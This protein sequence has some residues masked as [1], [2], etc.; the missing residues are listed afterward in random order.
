MP[1]FTRQNM[2]FYKPDPKAICVMALNCSD[3]KLALARSDAS[4]EIWNLNHTPFMEKSFTSNL[5]NYSV[6]GLTWC[7]RRLFSTGHHGWLVELDL[8]T[9]TMKDKWSITGEAGTC[10]D[11]RNSQIVVGTEQG[12]LNIFQVTGTDTQFEKFLDKQEGRIVCV[13]LNPTGE[14]VVAGSLNAIRIWSV[15]TGHALHKMVLSRAEANKNTIVWC[16]EVLSDFTIVSGDSR[17]VVTFWDGKLG[18]QLESYHSQN[19]DIRA[20]CINENEDS[21]YCSGINQLI[22]NYEK[23]KVGSSIKWVK[24]VV[25][26]ID[27]H[28]VRA[29]AV[30]HKKLYSAGTSGDLVCSY[31]PPKT[32]VKYA[33][34]PY[35]QTAS[36]GC[37]LILL[38]YSKHIEIWSFS[39]S[40]KNDSEHQTPRCP[41]GVD[42]QDRPRK[43]VKIQK[44]TKN[45]ENINEVEGIICSCISDDGK[46]IFLAT[47]SGFRLYALRVVDSHPKL[48]KINDLDDSNIACVKAAFNS[49]NNHL[50]VAL[51]NGN[52]V[53]YDLEDGDPFISQ[54][55]ECF[56]VHL[57][58]TVSLLEVS[59]C[60]KYLAVADAESNIVTFTY[61]SD[62][63]SRHLKLPKTTIPPTALHFQKHILK[64]SY[65]NNVVYE[66]NIKSN[67]W[68]ELCTARKKPQSIQP[69]KKIRK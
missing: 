44:V 9:L 56:K 26:K 67:E 51:S 38:R 40:R 59:S 66:F 61:T 65:A 32:V 58:D 69:P 64:V 29:M 18:A 12:Y 47:N 24:S 33:H 30:Y 37:P 39:C 45:S 63:Y 15:K 41:E 22:C 8:F 14:F 3:G 20:I 21:L 6:E 25:R 4:I 28:D 36:D 23:V 55:L 52:L 62:G 27:E 17:G 16:L 11:S 5:D 34:I 57:T 10:L 60:G 54:R 48:Q 35:V 7:S 50:I 19:S 13:K 1:C 49:K 43:L 42:P 68:T 31:H 2:S 53:V 46:W